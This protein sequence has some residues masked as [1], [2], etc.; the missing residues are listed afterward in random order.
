MVI[1]P[2]LQ[3]HAC[4][5]PVG[6]GRRAPDFHFTSKGVKNDEVVVACSTVRFV[7]E[8]LFDAVRRINQ[9]ELSVFK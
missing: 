7:S 3:V 9:A 1:A 6:F 5:L 8:V 2:L 4:Q